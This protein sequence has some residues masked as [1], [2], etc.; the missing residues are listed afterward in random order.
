MIAMKGSSAAEEVE[1]AAADLQR[2]RPG[3][4]EVRTLGADLIN[5]PTTVI[6]VEATD[7]TRLGWEATTDRRRRESRPTRRK[8]RRR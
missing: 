5:P 6:R 7:S 2:W 3:A 1:S 4:V 8:G